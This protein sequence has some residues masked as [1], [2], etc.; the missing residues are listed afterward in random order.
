[1]FFHASITHWGGSLD[2]LSMY[3]LVGFMIAYTMVR[4]TGNRWL[5][6]IGY[7]VIM[8]LYLVPAILEA[9]SDIVIPLSMIPYAVFEFLIWWQDK[10]ETGWWS[11]FTHFG[12]FWWIGVAAF[13]LGLTLQQLSQ[14][15]Q[16][17]CDSTALVQVH[18]IW[19][20][21]AGIMALML[22]LYWREREPL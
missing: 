7:P 1:M 15:G 8:G 18:G 21:L 16:P 13:A 5:F 12:K 20:I 2:Q 11:F 9:P 22:Y 14:T 19:H 3:F 17:L 10:K 4:L 6:Y